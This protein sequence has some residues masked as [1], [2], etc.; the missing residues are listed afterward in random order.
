MPWS[1]NISQLIRSSAAIFPCG[2]PVAS[3][4][5]LRVRS[6]AVIDDVTPTNVWRHVSSR[7]GPLPKGGAGRADGRTRKYVSPRR[8]TPSLT[9]SAAAASLSLSL[10]RS[11]AICVY[12]CH[13]L[14]QKDVQLFSQMGHSDP[15][16][17]LFT[18]L[19]LLPSLV[20]HFAHFPFASSNYINLNS[21]LTLKRR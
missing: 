18:W 13:C 16:H 14:P 11:L 7:S 19:H 4:L 3:L 10:A 21:G 6:L 20:L 12:L 9:L 8:L 15:K 2:R 1:S 17:L 5:A